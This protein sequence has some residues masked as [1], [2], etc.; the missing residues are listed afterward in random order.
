MTLYRTNS[1]PN[2][3]IY[4]YVKQMESFKD[5]TVCNNGAWT[6]NPATFSPETELTLRNESFEAKK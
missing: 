2:V 3:Y 6:T 1:L 5:Q 4:I